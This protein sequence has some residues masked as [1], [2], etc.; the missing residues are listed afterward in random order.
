MGIHGISATSHHKNDYDRACSTNE[1]LEKVG[2]RTGHLLVLGDEPLRSS[3]FRDDKGDLAIARWVYAEA[4]SQVEQL[5]KESGTEAVCPPVR[6]EV[7][8]GELL[9]LD[10]AWGGFEIEG[11]QTAN[12]RSGYFN[13]TTERLQSDG[14]FSFI[15]HRLV[16]SEP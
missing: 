1:F 15:V 3:F 14:H 4:G 6:F 9:L 8:E 11:C 12:V 7:I 5:L 13:V 10:S 2:C 16:R